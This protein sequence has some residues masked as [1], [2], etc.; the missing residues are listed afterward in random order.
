MFVKVLG[1]VLLAVCVR[2]QGHEQGHASSY[3]SYSQGHGG[4]LALG[5]LG[6]GYVH[7]APAE[8]H[9]QD[10]YAHPKYEFKYGVE[11]HHTGDIKSQSETRDGDVVKGQYSLHEPD[12][13]ILTVKYTADKHSG[14]NAEILGLA[15]LAACVHAQDGYGGSGGLSHSLGDYGGLSGGSSGGLSLGGYG[16]L[17]SYGGSSGG[18]GLSLGGGHGASSYISH[19]Q[20]GSSYGL[21]GGLSSLGESSGSS[22]GSSGHEDYHSHPKY[23]FKYGVED[24]HTGDIKQHEETRDGD[25]VKGSYS[26]HEPD[27]TILTVHYTADK[28][29]GF[30]AEVHREGHATHP[31]HLSHH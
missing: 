26:L 25:V 18:E 29:S 5:G 28:H 14:F 24:K 19:S 7:A 16:G 6:G 4:G 31:Q 27:G 17:E 9:H 8:D 10:Y 3:I 13:T 2:G 15:V 1:V 23:A 20:G 11:D 21:G 30:N 22:G 12:G